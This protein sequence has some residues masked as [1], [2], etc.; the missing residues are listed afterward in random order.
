MKTHAV[1]SL[2]ARA[3]QVLWGLAA[4]MATAGCGDSPVEPPRCASW[5][6]NAQH[7]PGRTCSSLAPEAP[8][9]PEDDGYSEPKPGK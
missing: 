9:P 1:T 6:V 4:L 2:R 7:V 3:A 5:L 8:V